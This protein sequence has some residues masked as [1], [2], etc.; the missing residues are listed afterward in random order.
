MSRFKVNKVSVD[1]QNYLYYVRGL[2]KTGKT[3]LFRALT[4]GTVKTDD[5]GEAHVGVVRVPDPRIDYFAAEYKPKKTT[6]ANIEF[7]DGA[8]KI[9]QED[10]RTK[11]GSDFFADVRQVD[12]LVHVVRGFESATGDAPN[13]TSDAQALND[14]LLLADLQMVENRMERIEKQLHGVK[15]GATTPATIEMALLERMKGLLEEGKSLKAVE[16]TPDEEKSIRGYD[17]LTLKP[18]MLMLN[19]PEEEIGETSETAQRFNAYCEDSG[20]PCFTLCA[21]VEMEVAELSDEE[22]AEF[23][24]SMGIA[25]PARNVLIQACYRALG[26]ISFITAGEPEVRAW[27]L[28]DGS[29]AVEAAGTIHSD[30]ARGF[31]RMEVANFK[32]V[33]AAGGWEAA[34]QKGIVQLQGKEYVMQDG[35]VVYIR[36][37][38]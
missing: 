25:E 5:F 3:T 4:R 24:S 32:D 16:F 14:E 37:K 30:L 22:E 29:K 27:T 35:D 8:A 20:I 9:A 1:I 31:I 21:K 12:A 15:K 10:S 7:I 23:L 26:L 18:M 34:K 2:K 13:P 11:F 28:K 38:V 36:F 33:E 6:Y 17:F 19:I